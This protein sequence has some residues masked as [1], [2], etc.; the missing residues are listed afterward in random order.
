MEMR[1]ELVSDYKEIKK[2]RRRRKEEPTGVSLGGECQEQVHF[3]ASGK[4]PDTR[5]VAPHFVT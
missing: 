3:W 2:R 5:W 4:V 1:E